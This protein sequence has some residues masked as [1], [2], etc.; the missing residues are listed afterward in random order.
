MRAF[1][2]IAVVGLVACSGGKRDA[3]QPRPE[4]IETVRVMADSAC[5]CETDKDCLKTVRADWDAQKDDLMKHG[6]TGEQQQQFDAELMRLRQCGDK[7]GLT[8]WMPPPAQ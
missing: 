1:I 6:L 5:A 4:L 8:F 3:P 7:G 2:L